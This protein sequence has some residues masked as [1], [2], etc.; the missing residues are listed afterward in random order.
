MSVEIGIFF[1][2]LCAIFQDFFYDSYGDN[3][4]SGGGDLTLQASTE[5]VQI[6]SLSKPC[7]LTFRN[8]SAA[9][10][11]MLSWSNASPIGIKIPAD[12]IAVIEPVSGII[13]AK[14]VDPATTAAINFYVIVKRTHES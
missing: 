12:S 5:W 10:E 13:Y 14:V 8:M 2:K 11:V 9:N 1:Q 6:A 3:T 7:I 4:D